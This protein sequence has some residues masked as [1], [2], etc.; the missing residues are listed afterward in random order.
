M[1]KFK[2]LTTG[3]K[4][5]LGAAVLLF[6]FSWFTWFEIEGD[7]TGVA[8]VNMWNG[9][10]VLAGLLLIAL[11]V[12]Q[13]LRLANINLEIG[14]TPAMITAALAVL[15]LVF[16]FIRWIDKPGGDLGAEV[17]DRTIW[18]WIGLALAIVLVVGAF[19]NMQAAGEGIADIR[20]AAAGAAASARGAV[21]RDDKPAAAASEAPDAPAAPAAAAAPPPAEAPSAAVAD[22]PAD[23][24]P[25]SP[26]PDDTPRAS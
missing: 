10:G 23:T 20:A 15:T 3:A 21:D 11:I 17:Y 1:D 7:I 24:P 13:G 2:E 9:I 8:S 25:D 16:V 6:V 19:L 22:P 4:L 12:W 26:E 5:V 14:V 18:A